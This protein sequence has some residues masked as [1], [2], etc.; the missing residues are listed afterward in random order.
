MNHESGSALQQASF[1][2][3]VVIA[4]GLGYLIVRERTRSA[5]RAAEATATA[6]SAA[7][8]PA[9]P[10][11]QPAPWNPAE[12][13]SSFAPLRPRSET[14]N[15]VRVVTNRVPI[16]V[17]TNFP[18]VTGTDTRFAAAPDA[19][20]FSAGPV[21]PVAVAVGGG[22]P[23]GPA[24]T[25]RVTL[26]G[27]SPPE[28]VIRSD[29]MCGRLHPAPF[30]TRHFVVGA[31]GGLANT[32]VYIKAGASPTAASGPGSTLDQVGCEYQPY[33]LGVQAGQTF[34]VRNSDPLLHNVHALPRQ[35]GNR[36][37]NI[38]QPVKGTTT[39]FVF[40]SPEVFV[41]FKCDVHP[42]M[43]AY[44]G[45]VDHPWFAV[46]D[47]NGNFALPAGLPAGQYTLAAVHQKAGE[48]TQPITVTENGA[49]PV[50]F[51]LDVPNALAK[52]NR[53]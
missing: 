25:G 24:V 35:Q 15:V 11:T 10:A 18:V 28:K 37:R 49:E 44:V 16:V 36:E 27:T 45:V 41:Q 39:P 13:K 48:V 50:H 33:V 32:F 26:R 38:G 47:G 20:S 12:M 23:S 2:L 9:N 17:R 6:A 53:P 31:N 7:T 51:T 46:T 19:P 3:L 8:A 34:H 5:E 21:V 42:W 14:N 1:A 4:A 29:V 52:T 30:T 43:F 40:N 22:G